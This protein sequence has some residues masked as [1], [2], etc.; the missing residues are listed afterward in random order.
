MTA[1][2]PCRRFPPPT[3]DLL[4]AKVATFATVGADG[5]PQLS[6]VWFLAEGDTI[7]LSLNDP[8]Q[9][10]K[11]LLRNPACTLFI[12]DLA[13]TSRYLELRVTPSSSP[14]TSTASPT[15]S[16]PSTAPT[17][18]CTIDPGRRA[19]SSPWTWSR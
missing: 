9:K 4:D 7:R 19:W 10:T 12:L 2:G 15:W 16:G 8:R 3:G 17:C 14:T 18:G 13:Q 5:R 6:E 1:A 11:N